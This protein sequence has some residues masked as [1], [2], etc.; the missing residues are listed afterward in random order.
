MSVVHNPYSS[1]EIT[2][3]ENEKQQL[4]NIKRKANATAEDIIN[5]I[6]LK[7]LN[8]EALD[9]LMKNTM[10]LLTQ[11]SYASSSEKMMV[12]DNDADG[13]VEVSNVAASDTVSVVG[14]RKQ[15]ES[16]PEMY[17]QNFMNANG[18]GPVVM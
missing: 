16:I 18:N 9:E 3:L 14:K 4:Q 5:H 13:Y 8:D 11:N 10:N 1:D 2:S 7:P 15:Q 17:A 6:N 12:W